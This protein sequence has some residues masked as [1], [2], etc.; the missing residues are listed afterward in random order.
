[1]AD[2]TVSG[3]GTAAVNQNYTANGTYSGK[4]AYESA[5][6]N[7]WIW[8]LNPFWCISVNKGDGSGGWYY[9]DDGGANPDDGEWSTADAGEDPPPTVMAA[10][11]NGGQPIQLRRRYYGQR[12]W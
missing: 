6:T 8:W 7:Y 5:D 12:S 11:G 2:Y 1:M 4:T 10:G 9:T 3:A